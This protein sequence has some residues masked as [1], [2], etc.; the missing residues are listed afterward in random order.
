MPTDFSV[1]IIGGGLVGLTAAKALADQGILVTVIEA[2]QPPLNWEDSSYTAQVYALNQASLH[3]LKNLNIWEAILPQSKTP[4]YQMDIWD[5]NHQGELRFSAMDIPA[6]QL[7]HIVESR[8]MI[9]AL[10]QSLRDHPCVTLHYPATPQSITQHQS[11]TQ[12]TLTDS[13]VLEADLII[14]ADGPNSWVRKNVDFTLQQ[15]PYNHDAMTMVIQSDKPHHNTA[16]QQFLPDGPIGVLPLHHT[17]Q[18]SIVW[19]TTPTHMDTLLALPQH[20]LNQA[21]SHA[22][23]YRW[24]HVTA[25]NTPIRFPLHM[26]HVKH[27]YNQH[28]VL[29]GDAAHTMHPLA[30]LGA[31]LG[32]F[33]AAVLADCLS[34]HHKVCSQASLTQALQRYQRWCRPR[35]TKYLNSMR[36]LKDCFSQTAGLPRQIA[37]L[38]L[39]LINQTPWIKNQ[40]ASHAMTDRGDIPP[41]AQPTPNMP[42]NS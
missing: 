8:A 32:L 41:L 1:I 22:L 14:G 24:G 20:D 28:V 31:N 34:K 26:R 16:L 7:G 17:H 40:L 27:Y 21:L 5:H 33:D 10:W 18:S 4:L 9:K 2:K 3:I 36:F 25:L 15:R 29:I 13:T 37:S 35:N 39:T 11:L 19:S 6:P 42:I 38:G 12:L 30:G 23:D